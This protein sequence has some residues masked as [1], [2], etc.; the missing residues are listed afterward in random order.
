MRILVLSTYDHGGAGKA[1]F[2]LFDAFRLSGHQALMLVKYK[3]NFNESSILYIYD[4]VNVDEPATDKVET[5]E[6]YYFYGIHDFEYNLNVQQLVDR[7]PFVP[8]LIVVT[9]V[10]FFINARDIALMQELTGAKVV[11]YPMDMSVLTGGCHYAWNCLGYTRDCSHC[12]AILDDAEKERAVANLEM[13]F[14]SNASMKAQLVVGSDQLLSQGSHA[15]AFSYLA[16]IPKVLLPVKEE[17]FNSK[18]R[19]LAKTIFGIPESSKVIFFGAQTTN[20][21]RK[22]VHLFVEALNHLSSIVDSTLRSQIYILLGGNVTNNEFISSIPFSFGF[23]GYIT[24]DRFLSVAYQAAHVYVSSSIQDSGPM[25]INEAV[26]CGTPVV[27]FSVGVSRDLI[28]DGTSGYLVE[29]GDTKEMARKIKSILQMSESD[30][31]Q[32]SNSTN[33]VGLELTSEKIF[34]DKFIV[35]VH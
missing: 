19:T 3:Q 18:V 2:R 23:S 6:D 1:S 5:D 32:M 21:K 33:K 25:M 28:L 13:K 4:L 7:L 24:D 9:W 22:G 12:P 14:R 20:E 26:M 8:E 10:S 16:E 29:V 30:F 17:V 11:Y 27:S 31:Q 35:A 15:S 34:V